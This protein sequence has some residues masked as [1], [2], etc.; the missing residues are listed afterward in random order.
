M[1]EWKQAD[2]RT[3]LLRSTYD[4]PIQLSAYLGAFNFD[5]IQPYRVSNTVILMYITL[6][7]IKWSSFTIIGYYYAAGMES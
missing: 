6:L 5:N 1:I 7:I 2:S 3:S 4:A